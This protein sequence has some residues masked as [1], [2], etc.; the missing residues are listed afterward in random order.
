ML[1]YLFI[2]IWFL[3]SYNYLIKFIYYLLTTNHININKTHIIK[4]IIVLL[5]VKNIT[6]IFK[7]NFCHINGM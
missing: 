5:L 1:I 3:P 2:I 7:I 6:F 4:F